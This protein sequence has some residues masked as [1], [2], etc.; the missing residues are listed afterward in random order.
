MVDISTVNFDRSLPTDRDKLAALVDELEKQGAAAIGLD[1]D[2]SPDDRG[3]FI[4]PRDAKLFNDWTRLRNVRVGVFRRE[5]LAPGT[6]ARP[7]GVSGSRGR[8]QTT[9]ERCAAR[10]LLHFRGNLGRLSGP[11]AGRAF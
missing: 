4:S 9:R 8:Y 11:T 7:F 10:L 3:N 1:I 2:F 6:V 5:G